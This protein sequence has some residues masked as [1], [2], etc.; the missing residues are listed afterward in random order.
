MAAPTFP[1]NLNKHGT[2]S[3]SLTVRMEARRKGGKTLKRVLSA[4]APVLT[5]TGL[6]MEG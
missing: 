4:A 3:G 5:N 1:K 6:L 2:P